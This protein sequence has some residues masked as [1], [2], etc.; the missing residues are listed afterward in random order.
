[1]LLLVFAR[2][3]TT[4]GIEKSLFQ[5]SNRY[6]QRKPSS[7]SLVSPLMS[8]NHSSGDEPWSS[9]TVAMASY[10]EQEFVSHYHA[11]LNCYHHSHNFWDAKVAS[12]VGEKLA[13][14]FK[15]IDVTSVQIDLREEF[16]RPTHYRLI[17]VEFFLKKYRK[18]LEIKNDYYHPC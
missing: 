2:E 11:K 13:F 7:S 1:M 4:N 3:Q 12:R 9:S 17:I 6:V 5:L 16:S 14:C 15:E 10:T 18:A 8:K